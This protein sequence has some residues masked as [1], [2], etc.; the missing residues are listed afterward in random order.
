MQWKPYPNCYMLN[1]ITSDIPKEYIWYW[2]INEH[3]YANK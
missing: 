2:I 3:G 1:N